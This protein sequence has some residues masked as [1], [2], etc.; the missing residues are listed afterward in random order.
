MAQLIS[1]LSVR[2]NF[3]RVEFISFVM[4]FSFTDHARQ[5]LGKHIKYQSY[6]FVE[7]LLGLIVFRRSSTAF[8]SGGRSPRGK[9]TAPSAV[10]LVFFSRIRT[11]ICAWIAPI[12]APCAMAQMTSRVVSLTSSMAS[13][14]CPEDISAFRL[15]SLISLAKQLWICAAPI[16]FMNAGDMVADHMPRW[17]RKRSW[18]LMPNVASGINGEKKFPDVLARSK[19][20][21]VRLATMSWTVTWSSTM[22]KGAPKG[23]RATWM[24]G[25]PSS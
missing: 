8:A 13:K 2:E 9:A 18:D 6:S 25:E 3:S 12:C 11:S 7:G 14:G 4:L 5:K 23:L 19:S 16:V 10:V 20:R 1:A 15:H 21:G 24:T 17:T 22:M